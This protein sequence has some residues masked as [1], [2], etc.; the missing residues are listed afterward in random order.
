[1]GSGQLETVPPAVPAPEELAG[2]AIRE[3][4]GAVEELNAIFALLGYGGKC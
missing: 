2:E 4:Q 1:M 3:W